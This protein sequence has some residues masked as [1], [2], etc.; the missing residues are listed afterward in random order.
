M[1]QNST[2]KSLKTSL[3]TNI[4][5]QRNY[6]TLCLLTTIITMYA[7][8]SLFMFFERLLAIFYGQEFLC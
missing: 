6:I 2:V 3:I 1:E 4:W 5:V 7:G 8:L